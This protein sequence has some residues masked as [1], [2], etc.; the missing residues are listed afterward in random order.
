MSLEANR[1][2]N[3][4]LIEGAKLFASGRRRGLTDDETLQEA[5]DEAMKA[6]RKGIRKR[7]RANAANA[8]DQLRARMAENLQKAG[9]SPDEISAFFEIRDAEM[10]SLGIENAR[11]PR[12]GPFQDNRQGFQGE[13]GGLERSPEFLR[14]VAQAGNEGED[15]NLFQNFGGQVGLGGGN[16][17]QNNIYTFYDELVN[18][19]NERG[20]TPFDVSRE[21]RQGEVMLPPDV[22]GEGLGVG[23]RPGSLQEYLEFKRNINNVDSPDGVFGSPLHLGAVK[24]AQDRLAYVIESQY[25]LEFGSKAAR[26]LRK[27][28]FEQDNLDRLGEDWKQQDFGGGRQLPDGV[29]RRQINQRG[30]ALENA[31]FMRD[32]DGN[33]ITAVGRDGKERRVRLG[34]R[35]GQVWGGPAL[36]RNSEGDWVAPKMDIDGRAIEISDVDPSGLLRPQPEDRFFGRAP[37][38]VGNAGGA[39]RDAVRRI[40]DAVNAGTLSLTDEVPDGRGRKRTVQNLLDDLNGVTDGRIG[41][42]ADKAE[43]EKAVQ[44]ALRRADGVF[45]PVELERARRK[46]AT[47]AIVG[48]DY[49]I[50]DGDGVMNAF[51]FGARPGVGEETISFLPRDP[52]QNTIFDVEPRLVQL[53][54]QLNQID[55]STREGAVAREGVLGEMRRIMI[56]GGLGRE[57]RNGPNPEFSTRRFNANRAQPQPALV[58]QA[59][60]GIGPAIE[61]GVGEAIDAEAQRRAE[62]GP[63]RRRQIRA[64]NEFIAQQLPEMMANEAV[65][66]AGERRGRPLNPIEEQAFR[67]NLQQEILPGERITGINGLAGSG[68]QP[69]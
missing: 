8:E 23:K 40:E 3:E 39:T 52:Q 1:R 45:T 24:E 63:A 18:A 4:A 6:A 28:Q 56:Q 19:Q 33:F 44:V 5:Y 29:A 43:A 67:R 32:Q 30:E 64:Q 17:N 50:R 25:Q 49:Q 57:G 15:P 53:Q 65:R 38:M 59:Y 9:Y 34:N 22:V 51:G 13:K 16:R 20:L 27:A 35:P 10:R 31:G 48:N 61:A 68:I 41:I 46:A 2:A 58:T 7:G 37:Q 21:R 14:R 62:V 55:G 42:K 47:A 36:E 12:L 69:L 11:D 60:S 26:D 66:V 54:D